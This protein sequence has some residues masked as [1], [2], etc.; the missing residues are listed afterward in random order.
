MMDW[1][2]I[3]TAVPDLYFPL[4][5]FYSFFID[6]RRN[7]VTNWFTGLSKD[8]F[9]EG[10]LGINAIFFVA[11]GFLIWS[12]RG[13]LFRGHIFTGI[14]VTFVFSIVYNLLYALH[15]AIV[16]RSINIS[17]TAWIIFACSLYTSLIA[18]LFF[19][20]LNKFQ[21]ANEYFSKN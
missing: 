21:P 15:T 16:F 18:P 17:A 14:L 8:F 10:S 3:G 19:Y 5:V 20:I 4:V 13:V 12:I 9:S 6:V 7:A 1:V 2:N 11:I